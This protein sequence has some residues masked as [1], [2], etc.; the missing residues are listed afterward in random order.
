MIQMRGSREKLVLSEE[1][2]N[3]VKMFPQTV[4]HPI[5]LCLQKLIV[6]VQKPMYSINFL[7]KFQNMCLSLSS[8]YKVFWF[9]LNNSSVALS[10]YCRQAAQAVADHVT[11]TQTP[12]TAQSVAMAELTWGSCHRENQ[13]AEF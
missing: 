12:I 5:C 3:Y 8:F 2:K 11:Q 13:T 7:T 6:P 10:G 9:V 4:S 1:M